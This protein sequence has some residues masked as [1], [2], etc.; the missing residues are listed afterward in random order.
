VDEFIDEFIAEWTIRR[1]DLFSGNNP[2]G[3]GL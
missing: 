1:W 3:E 2:L